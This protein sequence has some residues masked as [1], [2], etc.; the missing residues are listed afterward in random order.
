MDTIEHKR[1]YGENNSGLLLFLLL[2]M[3]LIS[4]FQIL[5]SRVPEESLDEVA[6]ILGVTAIILQVS[7]FV[8]CLLCIAGCSL[9][10]RLCPECLCHC[11]PL[12]RFS[13]LQENWSFSCSRSLVGY[14]CLHGPT[15]YYW[16][17]VPPPCLGIHYVA[18]SFQNVSLITTHWKDSQFSKRISLFHVAGP[19]WDITVSMVQLN[20]VDRLSV[21]LPHVPC[22]TSLSPWSTQ[23]SVDWLP[24]HPHTQGVFIVLCQ[25]PCWS[26]IV[27]P[28]RDNTL[29][30]WSLQI[31]W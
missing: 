22:G 8:A 5:A 19:L 28:S 20:T 27:H 11:N 3:S 31:A 24:W 16:L 6:D 18:G 10:S 13:V 14:H 2:F 23:N 1:E 29:H 30:H 17:V 4:S 7:A 21:T 9:H 26:A 15:K 12:G 25:C